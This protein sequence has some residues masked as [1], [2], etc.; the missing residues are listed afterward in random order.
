MLCACYA[1]APAMRLLCACYAPAMRAL[2]AGYSPAMRPLC[3]RY[4]SAMRLLCGCYAG[5]CRGWCMPG[6]RPPLA[7]GLLRG[8]HVRLPGDVVRKHACFD[9]CMRRQVRADVRPFAALG[10]STPGLVGLDAGAAWSRLFHFPS[11][12]GTLPFPLKA[13]SESADSGWGLGRS[14]FQEPETELETGVLAPTTWCGLA[15]LPSSI[16]P[17]GAR[18]GG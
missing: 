1:S 11:R 4:A 6:G 5:V 13:L 15:A 3:V 8:S 17:E 18:G 10:A 9:P 7:K 12:S 16:N 14:G 2:C